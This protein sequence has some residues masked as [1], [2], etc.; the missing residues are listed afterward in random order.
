MFLGRGVLYNVF[1]VFS[2]HQALVKT[3]AKNLDKNLAKHVIK[4]RPTNL[5]KTRKNKKTHEHRGKPV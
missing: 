3:L 1:I 4:I 5:S 2:L